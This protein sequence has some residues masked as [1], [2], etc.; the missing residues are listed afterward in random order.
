M[1]LG[2]LFPGDHHQAPPTNCLVQLFLAPQVT[3][4][5]ETTV[6]LGGWGWNQSHFK[7]MGIDP[8]TDPDQRLFPRALTGKPGIFRG[9]TSQSSPPWLTGQGFCED[10]Q[11]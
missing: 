1:S 9:L 3:S 7:A 5:A 10:H 6:G 2:G 4:T 11:I 8:T